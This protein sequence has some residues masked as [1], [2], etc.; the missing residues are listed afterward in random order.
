MARFSPF[1]LETGPLQ[2]KAVTRRDD[3]YETVASRMPF[4]KWLFGLGTH[5]MHR[6]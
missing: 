3:C 2:P 4:I 5:P 1:L 6:D